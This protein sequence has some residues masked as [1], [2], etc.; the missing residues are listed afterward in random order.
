MFVRMRILLVMLPCLIVSACSGSTTPPSP[1]SVAGVYV[2][3]GYEFYRWE[4]GPALMIWHDGIQLSDCTSRTNEQILVM[5]CHALSE[6]DYRFDWSLET[7]DGKTVDFF[8]NEQ[9]FDLADGDLFVITTSGGDMNLR[10]LQRNISKVQANTE[11]VIEFGLAEPAVQKLY[12]VTS[13]IQDCISSSEQSGKSQGKADAEAA[14]QALI[15]FFSHLHAGEYEQVEAYYGGSYT[16]MQDHNPDI[17]PDDRAALL[18]NACTINGAQC[19]EIRRATLTGAGSPTEFQFA[20]E[21]T[22]DDGSRFN[23]GPCC[24]E[25][26]RTGE[27]QTE[28][29]FTVGMECTGRYK[30]YDMPIYLP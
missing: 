26:M 6:D 12:Q 13:G 24:G 14:R 18:H 23:L 25:E 5:D 16:I 19:L 27:Y 17:D 29:I 7:K 30:V 28:F 1:E 8:L 22:N 4:E 9:E 21:F 15:A 10:Q 2:Q 11:Q 3:A 20:A